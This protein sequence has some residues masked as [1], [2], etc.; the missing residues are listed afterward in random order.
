MMVTPGLGERRDPPPELA[1]GERIG[2]AR[3]FVEE[4]DFRPVHECR[5]HR[6]ALLEAAGQLPGRQI[7]ERRQIELLHGPIDALAA[8]AP[9]QA[10]GA[11]EEGEVLADRELPIEGEFLRDIADPL[12]GGSPRA[13]EVDAGD[14]QRSAGRGEQAAEHAEGG[15][16]AGAVRPEETE[17]LAAGDVEADVVDGG[18]RRRTA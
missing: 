18:E 3:R 6:Q 5:G 1:P 14:A 13:G 12:A 9:A 4:E 2:A 17:D 15:R 11:G 16:L 7:R 8:P 10:I